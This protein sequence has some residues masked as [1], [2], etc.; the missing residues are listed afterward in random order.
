VLESQR[1]P[2]QRSCRRQRPGSWQLPGRCLLQLPVPPWQLPRPPCCELPRGRAVDAG[3]HPLPAPQ[4]PSARTR[5]EQ[6]LG[7]FKKAPTRGSQRAAAAWGSTCA[8]A[9]CPTRRL[10]WSV[11]SGLAWPYGRSRRRH[12]DGDGRLQAKPSTAPLI[13]ERT[14]PQ[15]ESNKQTNKQEIEPDPQRK[16][17]S[18]RRCN[19]CLP[20]KG[21]LSLGSS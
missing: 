7:H 6:P 5:P 12:E 14:E 1:G 9:G 4:P 11:H 10:L 20:E 15:R 13:S 19:E 3:P 2:R 18:V 16:H 17:N 21:R 8:P